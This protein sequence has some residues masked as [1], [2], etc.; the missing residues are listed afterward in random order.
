[1]LGSLPDDIRRVFERHITTEYVTIGPGSQP[2]AW[3]VTPY[4]DPGGKCLDVTTGLG[5]PKKARDAE[6]NPHVA[7][8]FSEP[9]GSNLDTPPMVLVQGKATVDD[10]D[11]DANRARYE[12]ESLA[13]L[14]GAK[15]ALPPTPVRRFFLWYFARISVHVRRERI[16]V[17]EGGDVTSEPE[18]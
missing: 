13:K 7:L 17:W 2:I 11:L 10:A 3:P 12:R 18:L 14:P 9:L 8:L 6:R 5:Y 15:P 1:M 4:V 16:S